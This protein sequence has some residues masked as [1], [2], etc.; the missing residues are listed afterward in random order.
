MCLPN[1]WWKIFHC[2]GRLLWQAQ[3]RAGNSSGE[4]R[5]WCHISGQFFRNLTRI[6]SQS[7]LSFSIADPLEKTWSSPAYSLQKARELFSAAFRVSRWL[8]LFWVNLSFGACL[9]TQ[10]GWF[11]DNVWIKPCS[12]SYQS[13]TWCVGIKREVYRGACLNWLRCSHVTIYGLTQGCPWV[14]CKS[15]EL[16]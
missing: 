12:G 2:K 6:P 8:M 15:T 3:T 4:K 1:V 5:G 7:G 11:C 16:H 10:T 14:I 9:Y 13:L